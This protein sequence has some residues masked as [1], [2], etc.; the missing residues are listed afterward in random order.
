VGD[1]ML[2]SPFEVAL[3]YLRLHVELH[4]KCPPGW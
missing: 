4:H 3:L 2:H 1:Q